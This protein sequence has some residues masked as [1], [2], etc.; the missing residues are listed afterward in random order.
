[1]RLSQASGLSTPAKLVLLCRSTT[2]ELLPS[3]SV[4]LTQ[5]V[6]EQK[7]S[8][9][10][11]R[12]LLF[13]S[14]PV[15]AWAKRL[16]SPTQ[17][18]A[19]DS[20]RVKFDQRPVSVSGSISPDSFG[21]EAT[22]KLALVPSPP[23]VNVLAYRPGLCATQSLAH[24]VRLAWASTNRLWGT[25]HWRHICSGPWPLPAPKCTTASGAN[26]ARASSNTVFAS[27]VLVSAGKDDLGN[28]AIFCVLGQAQPER[29]NQCCVF[30][31]VAFWRLRAL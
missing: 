9:S 1:M 23:T 13:C 25:C 20:T 14:A 24:A 12:F 17:S 19:I 29:R 2:T 3:V 10:S 31:E 7:K 15:S 11:Q 5:K 27:S 30:A 4:A 8:T 21:L 6:S 16:S 22:L 26:K 18:A 28:M